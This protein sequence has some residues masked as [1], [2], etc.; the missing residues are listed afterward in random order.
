MDSVRNLT[1]ISALGS[2][3]ILNLSWFPP[4]TPN[5]VITDYEVNVS[6][7]ASSDVGNF[8]ASEDFPTNT[9][10]SRNITNLS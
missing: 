10:F 7:S 8:T 2:S 6:T 1:V 9:R 5:G 4:A 3:T